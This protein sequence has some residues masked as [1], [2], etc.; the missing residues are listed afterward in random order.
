MA[1]RLS[2]VLGPGIDKKLVRAPDVSRH[3]TETLRVGFERG[4]TGA[5]IDMQLFS[6]RWDLALER[7]SAPT[8]IWL[9]TED[10]SVPHMAVHRLAGDIPRVEFTRLEGQGHFWITRHHG[11]VLEWLAETS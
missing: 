10:R 7:I 5:V 11:Q 6:R 8:R 2:A 9:G 3:L 1:V 4:V